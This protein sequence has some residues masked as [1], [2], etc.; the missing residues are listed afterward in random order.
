MFYHILALCPLNV[1]SV[2]FTILEIQVNFEESNL[3]TYY[4]VLDEILILCLRRS[5]SLWHSS[6]L[7]RLGLSL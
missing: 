2:L 7:L 6:N 5:L 3:L 1:T 4:L